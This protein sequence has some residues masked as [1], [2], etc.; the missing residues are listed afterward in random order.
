MERCLY[1]MEELYKENDICPACG[2]ALD[3]YSP[4]SYHLLPGSLLCGRYYVGV[5]REY[6]GESIIYA[7]FDKLLQQKV[8]IKE[9]F[10]LEY[11]VRKKGRQHIELY[12]DEFRTPYNDGLKRFLG[13]AKRLAKLRDYKNIVKVLDAFEYNG[14]AY[15]ITDDISGE[16]LSDIISQR[17]RLSTKETI[18]LIEPIALTL[19]KVH[20]EGVIHR[21][22]SPENIVIE[23][24]GTARLTGFGSLRHTSATATK[25]LSVIIDPGFTP[26]EQYISSGNQGAWTD[27]YALAATM[28]K[29]IT[30]VTP[31]ESV[32]RSKKDSLKRPS[33]YGIEISEDVDRAIMHALCTDI[34]ERTLT[35]GDFIE[36]LR[37][38]GRFSVTEKVNKWQI[39][40]LLCALLWIVSITASIYMIRNSDDKD[41][42]E[43][44][45]VSVENTGS[46]E[47]KADEEIESKS[48]VSN[49]EMYDSKVVDNTEVITSEEKISKEKDSEEV[50]TES[51]TTQEVKTDNKKD[52]NSDNTTERNTGST[53]VT[54]QTSAAQKKQKESTTEKKTESKKKT[55]A[56][57]TEKKQPEKKTTESTTKEAEKAATE[58]EV[59]YI[60]D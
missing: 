6:R 5:C 29:C 58:D 36:E 31:E 50:P 2:K 28:Y 45:G 52:D 39:Y 14:T 21:N 9:F 11:A 12:V 22:I 10:P 13:E 51:M 27:V 4:E 7:G 46:V 57:K 54:T 26:E 38:S 8:N 41:K 24:D 32:I 47:N 43:N 48:G 60:E 16:K 17:K 59:L 25:T 33:E 1:C 30:G 55:T 35:M 15:Q 18:E 44:A 49:S 20:S 56:K 19:E 40:W 3:L 23:K 37:G 53:T 34:T 42:R